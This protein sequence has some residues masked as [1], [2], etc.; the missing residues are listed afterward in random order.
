MTTI[1]RPEPSVASDRYLI[2]LVG[3]VKTK[4]ANVSPAR[5]LY[6]SAL[7]LGRRASVE[8]RVHRWFILSGQHGLVEPDQ[9]V[10]PDRRCLAEA[11]SRQRRAWAS[12]VLMSLE[13]KLGDLRRYTFEIHAGA[14]YFAYGLRDGLRGAGAL[15]EVPTEGLSQGKQLQYYAGGAASLGDGRLR[16]SAAAIPNETTRSP[17]TNC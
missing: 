4:V 9:C 6:I 7:F 8:G 15:V 2:G 3:G 13:A 1:S 17:A 11:S 16:L 14:D 5:D 10:T 12:A